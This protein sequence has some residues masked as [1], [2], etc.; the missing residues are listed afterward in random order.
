VLNYIGI[1]VLEFIRINLLDYL[2]IIFGAFFG[3]IIVIGS[4]VLGCYLNIA[5]LYY[6]AINGAVMLVII[7]IYEI[8]KVVRKKH[9]K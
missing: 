8:L 4:A 3:L 2:G 6:C 1:K 7:T 5:P 9:N